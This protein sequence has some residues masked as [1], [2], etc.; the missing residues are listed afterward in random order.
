LKALEPTLTDK[1]FIYGHNARVGARFYF[2]A[3]SRSGN[4]LL[5]AINPDRLKAAIAAEGGG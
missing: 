4:A 3:F 2:A 1:I 5:V